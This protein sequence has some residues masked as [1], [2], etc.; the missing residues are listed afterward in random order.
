MAGH[1]LANST[2][3]PARS[4]TTPKPNSY[5]DEPYSD[6]EFGSHGSASA[7]ID[8]VVVVPAPKDILN[9]Y[10]VQAT[11]Y[12]QQVGS[13]LNL[14]GVQKKG[15]YTRFQEYYP[16]TTSTTTER[17]PVDPMDEGM[18][19][20]APLT[21]PMVVRV[22]L[23]GTPVEDSM[24]LPQDEDLKQYKMSQIKIPNL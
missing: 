1:P 16:Q 5:E 13:A 14:I 11:R 24:P 15:P 23:D 17:A 8:N 18:Y 20:D 6:F 7:R 2:P 21:G 10:N 9:L 19:Q 12:P 4:T 3:K 22:Y